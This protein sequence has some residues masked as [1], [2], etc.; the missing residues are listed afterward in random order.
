[1][2][3][4]PYRRGQGQHCI[5]ERLHTARPESENPRSWRIIIV[6]SPPLCPF[7]LLGFTLTIPWLFEGKCEMIQV[8]K[9]HCTL[10]IEYRDTEL[11]TYS[12]LRA[13]V[14]VAL[15]RVVP[16][17]AKTQTESDMIIATASKIERNRFIVIPFYCE[18]AA[19]VM[20]CSND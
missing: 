4:A 9:S 8:A 13:S 5:S 16:E 10:K 15:P 14:S 18:I 11:S 19:F 6:V 3:Q 7:F 2:E 17:T 1:M 12:V 20:F